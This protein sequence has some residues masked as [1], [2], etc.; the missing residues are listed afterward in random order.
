MVTGW[1]KRLV[2]LPPLCCLL[3]AWT[4]S[5]IGIEL[6]PYVCVTLTAASMTAANDVPVLCS[7]EVSPRRLSAADE[8][9]DALT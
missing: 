8:V 6:S 7:R 5:T 9:A 2:R 3:L 4:F 1:R